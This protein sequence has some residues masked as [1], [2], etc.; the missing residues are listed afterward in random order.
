MMLIAICLVILPQLLIAEENVGCQ[1]KGAWCDKT[2]FHRCC[3]DLVCDLESPG[4]GKCVDCYPLEHGCISDE[5]CCS[6]RCHVF[7]CKPK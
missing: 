5:E 4:K 3:E 1:K 7:A 2:L 6:K